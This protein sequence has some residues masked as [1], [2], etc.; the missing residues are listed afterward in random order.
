[1][2]KGDIK[3]RREVTCLSKS[4]S[5][6]LGEV[7]SDEAL[8]TCGHAYI[9]ARKGWC[10]VCAEEFDSSELWK[11]KRKKSFRCPHCN[12]RLEVKRSPNK[13]LSENKYYFS[14]VKVVEGWQVLTTYFC[15]RN[16]TKRELLVG[17]EV[18]G[19]KVVFDAH[20]VYQWWIK[21][22]AT[23]LLLSY[24]TR[25]GFYCDQWNFFS[26]FEFRKESQEHRLLGWIGS[27]MEILPILKRNGLKRLYDTISL[28]EQVMQT[29]TNPKAEILLKHKAQSLFESLVVSPNQVE[30]YWPSIR[31]ALRHNFIPK[32]GSL[33]L[34]F[35]HLLD[36][37]D[38]DLRNPHYICSK[39]LLAAHRA[40]LA[41]EERRRGRRLAEW[42]MRMAREKAEKM[43]D[44][45]RN[46]KNMNIEYVTRMGKMLGVCVKVEDIEVKALQSIEDFYHE[47]NA[48]K[49]CVFTNRYYNK[50]NTLILSAKVKGKRTETVE[51][52]TESWKIMQCRGPHNSASKRHSD[53]VRVVEENIYAFRRMA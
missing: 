41:E 11:N 39:N 30:R 35:L 37:H 53:I 18:E 6:N 13:Y 52:N 26:R 51:V 31:V 34:D 10:D 27:G 12:T 19:P 29:L 2:A 4:F 45:L 47:G 33:Y 38:K 15:E 1:M 21:P 40:E 16:S 24:S 8:R 48:L 22:G 5:Y 20:V 7:H 14:T 43:L 28:K 42:E 3:N 50:P 44:Q 17:V 23:P 25:M 46:D 36:M 9:G 32:D 49:H